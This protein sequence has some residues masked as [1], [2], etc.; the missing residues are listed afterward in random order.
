MKIFELIKLVFSNK[1][2][3]RAILHAC[4]NALILVICKCKNSNT[5]DWNGFKLLV[6]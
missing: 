4:I 6:Q 1:D 3:I 5:I 2:L